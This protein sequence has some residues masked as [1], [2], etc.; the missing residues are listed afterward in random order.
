MALLGNEVVIFLE[1]SDQNILQ[2][3][4]DKEVIW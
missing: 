3:K 4:G 1:S 2:K